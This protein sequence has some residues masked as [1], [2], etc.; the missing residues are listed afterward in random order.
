VNPHS[1]RGPVKVEENE[2][3]AKL[4][5]DA[6]NMESNSQKHVVSSTDEGLINIGAPTE[7]YE[8]PLENR[9]QRALFAAKELLAQTHKFKMD[10]NE[11]NKRLMHLMI[12]G[13]EA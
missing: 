2:R 1:E 10:K 5:S 8:E 12:N 3:L 7:T 13:E 11:I 6:G 4:I 9:E